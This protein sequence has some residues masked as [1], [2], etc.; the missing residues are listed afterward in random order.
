MPTHLFRGDATPSAKTKI[1]TDNAGPT[2][3]RC[4]LSRIA[5]SN[6]LSTIT[7]TSSFS[8]PTPM[9]DAKLQE[10]PQ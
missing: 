9:E 2:L 7:I 1:D 10:Q 3:D 6:Q 4:L 5:D 8:T